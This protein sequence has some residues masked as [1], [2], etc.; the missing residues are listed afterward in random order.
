MR[1]YVGR[2]AQTR[3]VDERAETSAWCSQ[4]TAGGGP[5]QVFD[6]ADVVPVVREAAKSGTYLNDAV[7]VTFKVL[8]EAE[9][10]LADPRR[11]AS[12]WAPQVS[13]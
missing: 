3:G 1:L 10:Q 2:W 8:A 13:L 12:P 6:A 7:L 4:V 5:I 11:A 9:A